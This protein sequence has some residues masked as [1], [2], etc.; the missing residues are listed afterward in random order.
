M[1]VNLRDAGLE[2]FLNPDNI[3]TEGE[4]LD[5]IEENNDLMSDA[6]GISKI[7]QMFGEIGSESED[8]SSDE[9]TPIQINANE[10]DDS[11]E[12][13]DMSGSEEYSE[14]SGS[15]PIIPAI[16]HEEEALKEPN[17]NEEEYRF[18][19]TLQA[20]K[21]PITSVKKTQKHYDYIYNI[22]QSVSQLKRFEVPIPPYDEQLIHTDIDYAADICNQMINATDT[23][24][25]SDMFKEIILGFTKLVSFVFDGK[26]TFGKKTLPNMTGYDRAVK[27]K[28]QKIRRSTN[29]MAVKTKN[30][31]G[32]G[33]TDILGFIS[34]LGF[35][36]VTTYIA[37]NM[38]SQEDLLEPNEDDFE[39]LSEDEE[40]DSEELY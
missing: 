37:N 21:K 24:T 19:Q 26:R 15:V 8:E 2:K 38:S 39:A 36:L 22:K 28:I 9:I 32:S 12:I 7:K 11:D 30:I 18:D 14:S 20:K 13:N 33:A 29:D 34:V 23:N 25:L 35:P 27:V 16:I 10:E 31:L 1:A 5:A 6:T 3:T 17:M 40:S 4:K